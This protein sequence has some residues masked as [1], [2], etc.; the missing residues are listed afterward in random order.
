MNTGLPGGW[1]ATR[2][3]LYLM[4][5]IP[6]TPGMA[7]KTPVSQ[8]S[9]QV[10]VKPWWVSPLLPLVLFCAGLVLCA[11]DGLHPYQVFMRK[12]NWKPVE[13]QLL[14]V[15]ERRQIQNPATERSTVRE[16]LERRPQ[17]RIYQETVSEGWPIK[18]KKLQWRIRLYYT[19]PWGNT[20]HTQVAD[21]PE[22]AFPN[23][24]AAN[25]Y[26]NQRVRGSKIKVWVNPTSPGEATAFLEY[27]R[28]WTLRMGFVAVG[29]GLIWLLVALGLGRAHSRREREH[30]AAR[31][32][33]DA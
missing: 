25:S 10:P 1:R 18:R 11:L 20:R 15:Y 17:K 28:V 6:D 33:G 27:R 3:D 24:E 31:Q 8:S 30:Q 21:G 13:G 19:Y 16:Y 29:L 7:R 23:E 14:Q 5:R 12:R 26:L 2:A 9:A 4:A 32:S 22:R